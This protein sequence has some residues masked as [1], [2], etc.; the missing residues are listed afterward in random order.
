MKEVSTNVVGMRDGNKMPPTTSE[1][2]ALKEPE[3][4]PVHSSPEDDNK[5]RI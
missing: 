2:Q 3:S 5:I 4:D 1:G